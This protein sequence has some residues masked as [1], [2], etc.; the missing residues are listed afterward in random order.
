MGFLVYESTDFHIQAEGPQQRITETL[1]RAGPSEPTPA[2]PPADAGLGS[3]HSPAPPGM[4][5]KWNRS[6]R[7]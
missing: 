7:A 5:Q 6:A 4:W 2:R 3:V 1:V